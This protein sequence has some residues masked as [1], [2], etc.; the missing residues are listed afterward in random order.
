MPRRHI[1]VF[2]AVLL[3]VFFAPMASRVVLAQETTG[4]ILGT[5]TDPSGALIPDA[6]VIVTN[7]QTNNQR[8]TTTT[9]A[10]LFNFASLPIGDYELKVSKTGFRQYVQSNVHLDVNDKLNFHVALTVG[11]VTQAVT[12]TGAAPILQTASGEVSNLVG[13]AQMA[14]LPLNGRDFNQLI[15]LAPGVAPD[16]GRV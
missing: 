16:N 12:V 4:T 15:D 3:G 10:G 5:V 9:N 8:T 1:P 7:R 6:Q 14:A 11:A 13:S 2:L